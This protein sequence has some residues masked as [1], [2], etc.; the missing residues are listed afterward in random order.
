M[1]ERRRGGREDER[2]ERRGVRAVG[3]RKGRSEEGRRRE[4]R[5]KKRKGGSE[6]GREEGCE[7]RRKEG[8]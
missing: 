3:R 7:E 4:V 1:R 2:K 6:E 5:E 8:G